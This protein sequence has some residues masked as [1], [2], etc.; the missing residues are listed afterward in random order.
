LGAFKSTRREENLALLD[1][2]GNGF[3]SLP[4]E[5]SAARRFGQIRG[6]LV[7]IQ[8]LAV[9]RARAPSPGWHVIH[10]PEKARVYAPEGTARPTLLPLS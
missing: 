5:G 10:A 9:G 1:E 8:P 6:E 7:A 4:F 2:L 3:S